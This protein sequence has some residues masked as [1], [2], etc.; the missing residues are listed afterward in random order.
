[1]SKSR[2]SKLGA[3][4]EILGVSR[5]TKSK[6]SQSVFPENRAMRRMRKK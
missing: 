4:R 2:K 1:M 3:Y 5:Y 6:V